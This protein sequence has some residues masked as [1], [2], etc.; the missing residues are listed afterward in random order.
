MF[1]NFVIKR[2]NV[3]NSMPKDIVQLYLETQ[4]NILPNICK[5]FNWNYHQYSLYVQC[6]WEE[7]NISKYDRKHNLNK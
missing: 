7:A 2:Q 4:L 5:I 6:I 3:Q 1:I